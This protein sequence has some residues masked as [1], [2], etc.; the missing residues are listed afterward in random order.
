M[1][2][3]MC[4]SGKKTQRQN[5]SHPLPPKITLEKWNIG[6]KKKIKLFFSWNRPKLIRYLFLSLSSLYPAVSCASLLMGP[7]FMTD[8]STLQRENTSG[9]TKAYQLKCLQVCCVCSF[10]KSGQMNSKGTAL[11][12][13]CKWSYELVHLENFVLF[14]RLLPALGHSQRMTRRSIIHSLSKRWVCFSKDILYCHVG[15]Q[16]IVRHVPQFLLT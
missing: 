10:Q 15:I 13:Y 5:K 9:P 7:V 12:G 8:E 11:L 1:N 14:S 6:V 2:L 16:D 3:G 4:W